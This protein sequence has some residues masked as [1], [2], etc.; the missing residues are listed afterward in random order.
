MWKIK[1]NNDKIREV[2]LKGVLMKPLKDKRLSSYL[3]VD[4]LN[5]LVIPIVAIQLVISFLSMYLN[6]WLGIIV[7]VLFIAM[8]ISIWR[9]SDRIGDDFNTYIS[10][11]S[12]QIKR[13]EHEAII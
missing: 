7:L 5:K 6:I 10:N 11:L 2:K 12:Y 4:S 1:A 9:L 8:D 13:G 3:S